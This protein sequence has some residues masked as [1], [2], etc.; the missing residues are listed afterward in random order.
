[1]DII[2]FDTEDGTRYEVVQEDGSVTEIELTQEQI[3]ELI[4]ISNAIEA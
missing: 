3:S 2:A 1:M 4:P